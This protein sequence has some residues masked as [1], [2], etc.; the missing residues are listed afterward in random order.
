VRTL[1]VV[2]FR[3]THVT[4]YCTREVVAESGTGVMSTHLGKGHRFPFGVCVG[5]IV[6]TDMMKHKVRA[7][8]KPFQIMRSLSTGGYLFTFLLQMPC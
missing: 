2:V 1:F 8:L 6:R 4:R 5:P 3:I 7:N